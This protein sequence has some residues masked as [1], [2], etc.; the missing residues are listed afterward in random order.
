MGSRAAQGRFFQWR[1]LTIVGGVRE[2]WVVARRGRGKTVCA[3]GACGVL[4]GGPSTS[5]LEVA[6][7]K[8][9]V[10]KSRECPSLGTAVC[11]RCLLRVVLQASSFVAC[12]VRACGWREPRSSLGRAPSRT[13]KAAA[14]PVRC[15]AGAEW[16]RSQ[17][18][19]ALTGRLCRLR[20]RHWSRTRTVPF[21]WATSN[22]RLER[23]V[24][25]WLMGRLTRL[26]GEFRSK[27][28][29]LSWAAAQALR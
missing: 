29:Q 4:L 12:G 25:G 28:P 3:R 15:A 26:E 8:L 2:R 10:A 24:N 6:S 17:R 11:C 9:C 13:R 20:L 21:G 23:S 18:W 7:G 5:P 19:G 22:P 1:P 14:A 27:R 16:L